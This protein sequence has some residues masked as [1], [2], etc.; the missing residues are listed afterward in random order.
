M[1]VN[2]ASQ[3]TIAVP[4]CLQLEGGSLPAASALLLVVTSALIKALV[5]GLAFALADIDAMALMPAACEPEPPLSTA[6]VP[7]P[8]PMTTRAARAA[9]QG[10]SLRRER[11]AGGPAGGGEPACE[12]GGGP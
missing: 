12:P 11:E 6:Q 5:F 4:C 3:V 8:A 10:T 1:P 9:I 7:T 2:G